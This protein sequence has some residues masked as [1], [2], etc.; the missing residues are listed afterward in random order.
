MRR[1]NL[2]PFPCLYMKPFELVTEII[3]HYCTTPPCGSATKCI[4][5]N[6][7]SGAAALSAWMMLLCCLLASSSFTLRKSSFLSD[8]C[9]NSWIFSVQWFLLITMPSGLRFQNQFIYKKTLAYICFRNVPFVQPFSSYEKPKFG[10][11][12]WFLLTH[13]WQ[14]RMALTADTVRVQDSWGMVP[15][16]CI[17]PYTQLMNTGTLW[18]LLTPGSKNQSFG[19]SDPNDSFKRIWTRTQGSFLKRMHARFFLGTDARN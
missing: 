8:D 6:V 2:V 19:Y 9:L 7:H 12:L 11:E 4:C 18:L 14:Q 5:S 17:P 10:S 1:Q 16:D 15:V 13:F 3:F